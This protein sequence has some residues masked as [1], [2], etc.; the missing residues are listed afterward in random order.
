MIDENPTQIAARRIIV[1]PV[2]MPG[3]EPGT[4]ESGA[5]IVQPA[6]AGWKAPDPGSGIASPTRARMHASQK[7]Q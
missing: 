6:A 5:Y 3:A 2:V 1:W 7:I 4:A